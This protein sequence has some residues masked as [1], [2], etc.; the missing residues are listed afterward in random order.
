MSRKCHIILHDIIQKDLSREVPLS[1]H[2]QH[3]LHKSTESLSLSCIQLMAVFAAF[4]SII[5]A[6]AMNMSLRQKL[7]NGGKSYGPVRRCC[8]TC[9]S[10]IIYSAQKIA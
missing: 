1:S 3:Q 4:H 10:S 5:L 9:F 6:L 8:I 2:K 7:L